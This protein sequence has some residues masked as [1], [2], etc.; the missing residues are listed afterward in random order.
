MSQCFF[1]QEVDPFPRLDLQDQNYLLQAVYFNLIELLKTRFKFI[2]VSDH[3]LFFLLR[4]CF[5]SIFEPN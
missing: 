1:R 3:K 5:F 2:N 4:T